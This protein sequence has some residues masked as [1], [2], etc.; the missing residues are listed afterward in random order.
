MK[1]SVNLLVFERILFQHEKKATE[2]IEIKFAFKYVQNR[3]VKLGFGLVDS[4]KNQ[5][6]LKLKNRDPS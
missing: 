6:I 4:T 1:C 2:N 5:F 3:T